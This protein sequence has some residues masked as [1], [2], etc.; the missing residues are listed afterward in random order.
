MMLSSK[1]YTSIEAAHLYISS[2]KSSEFTFT[3]PSMAAVITSAE[4]SGCSIIFVMAWLW[5]MK[6]N[7][8]QQQLLSNIANT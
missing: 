3:M 8:Q 5:K 4:V 6:N 7:L 2:M 1:A